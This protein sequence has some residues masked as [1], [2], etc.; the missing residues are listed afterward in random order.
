MAYRLLGKIPEKLDYDLHY[1]EMQEDIAQRRW[2]YA[3]EEVEKIIK[4]IG[5]LK[6]YIADM[7]DQDQEDFKDEIKS[8]LFE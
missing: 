6:F 1:K 3:M 2:D 7:S 8:M 4:P 5:S